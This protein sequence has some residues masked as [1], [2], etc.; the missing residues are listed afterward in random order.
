MPIPLDLSALS[1]VVSRLDD[2][3][4]RHLSSPQ[5]LQLQDG[6]ILRLKSAYE[7][8]LEVMRRN[9]LMHSNYEEQHRDI[10]LENIIFH[11]R[12][13]G[14]IKGNKQDWLD[15]HDMYINAKNAYTETSANQ[16]LKLIPRFLNE[17]KNLLDALLMRI[18]G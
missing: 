11:A 10:P 3:L 4:S 1:K 5:D 17:A 16:V 6:L 12:E 8:S 7:L 18:K 14:L 15:Y 13:Q 9:F 2:G